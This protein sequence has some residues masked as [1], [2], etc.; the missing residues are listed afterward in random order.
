VRTAEQ[1]VGLIAQE[2]ADKPRFV[3]T[4][5]LTVDVLARLQTF[6]ASIPA[7]FDLDYAIGV[8]LDAVGLRIGRSRLVPYP[9]QGLYFSLDAPLLGLDRG[10]WKGPYDTGLGIYRLDDDTFR[11]LLRAKI[12]TNTWNGTTAGEQAIYN[13]FFIDPATLV[14][15]DDSTISGL[16]ENYF[17]LDDTMRGLDQGALAPGDTAL[18][19]ISTP[20]DMVMTVGIAGK[21]PS[22]EDIAILAQGLIGAKPEG[23]TV[24]YAITSTN[25]APVFGL[26]ADDPYIGGFDHGAWGVSPAYMLAYLPS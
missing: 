2:H 23:V 13:A 5:A 11:R 17:S 3:A 10:V 25:G 20:A 18:V 19:S 8:Q 21:I 4:V 22:I 12:L 1:Y 6:I 24:Q 16:P 15:V 9:L 14:F 26:D 7:A